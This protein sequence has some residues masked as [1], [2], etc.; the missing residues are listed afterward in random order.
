MFESNLME[1]DMKIFSSAFTHG[2]RIPQQFT[3]EG[4]DISPELSWSDAPKAAKS[5]VLIVHDPDAPRVNGFVHW[6]VYNIPPT[7]NHLRENAG[8]NASAEQ[9]GVQGRNDAGKTGYMGPCPPSGSHR[10]FFRLYAL[11]DHL[12]LGPGASYPEVIAAMEG[13]IIEQAEL[14]G[15]YAKIAQKSA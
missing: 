1:G 8:K 6:L 10:Y 15:T 14:M 4:Q 9:I 3:C 5:L 12:D 2:D 7:V 13:K 11:R